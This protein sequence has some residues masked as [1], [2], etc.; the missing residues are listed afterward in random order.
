MAKPHRRIVAPAR[1]WLYRWTFFKG[2]KST[3]AR[4]RKTAANIV[5]VVTVP[6]TAVTPIKS[7]SPPLAAAVIIS[8]ISGSQGPKTKMMNKTQGVTALADW[9]SWTCVCSPRCVWECT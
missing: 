4:P 2:R 6:K 5:A 1:A 8:G 3:P 7:K 9:I